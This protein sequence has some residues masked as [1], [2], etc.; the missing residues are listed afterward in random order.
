MTY[1]MKVLKNIFGWLLP[2]TTTPNQHK[3][4]KHLSLEDQEHEFSEWYINEQIKNYA[5]DKAVLQ[6]EG[7]Q[8]PHTERFENGKDN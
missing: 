5:D 7:E 1:L 4:L 6:W 8:I 2:K 3:T